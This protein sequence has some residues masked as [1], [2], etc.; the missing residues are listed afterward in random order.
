M[1]SKT[2]ILAILLSLLLF[3]VSLVIQLSAMPKYNFLGF[4]YD[5]ILYVLLYFVTFI[6]NI[7]VFIFLYIGDLSDEIIPFIVVQTIKFVF[8]TCIISDYLK[9]KK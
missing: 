1:R 7:D 9:K 6:Y 3:S 5:S 4:D 8:F 2:V